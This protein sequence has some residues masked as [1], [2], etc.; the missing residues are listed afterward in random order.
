MHAKV[1]ITVALYIWS[2]LIQFSRR[3]FGAEVFTVMQ[4]FLMVYG[5][6]IYVLIIKIYLSLCQDDH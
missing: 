1:S 2:S 6:Y 3:L 5:V 4:V